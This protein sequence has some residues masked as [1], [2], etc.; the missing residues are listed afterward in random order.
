MDKIHFG[1]DES[2]NNVPQR[3]EKA[4]VKLQEMEEAARKL[5]LMVDLEVRGGSLIVRVQ[6]SAGSVMFLAQGHEDRAYLQSLAHRV[7][8]K[9]NTTLYYIKLAQ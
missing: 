5:A 1:D 7:E 3:P 2:M 9:G 6:E 8:R 4:P